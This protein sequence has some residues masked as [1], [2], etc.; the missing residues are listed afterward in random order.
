M[1]LGSLIAAYA[2]GFDLDVRH[3]YPVGDDIDHE[4]QGTECVCGPQMI[5]EGGARLV[6]VHHSLD[7][8]E[9]GE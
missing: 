1:T 4:L 8:R 3:V 2:E 5:L 9:A 6:V 7:G